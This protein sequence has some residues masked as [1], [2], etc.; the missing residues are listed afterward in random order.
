MDMERID[1]D[2]FIN[3]IKKAY[4]IILQFDHTPEQFFSIVRSKNHSLDHPNEEVE[5]LKE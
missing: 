2:A 3:N 4:H 1:L 5:H